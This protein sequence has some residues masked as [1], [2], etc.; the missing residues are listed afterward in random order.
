MIKTFGWS[1]YSPRINCLA[2]KYM[3]GKNLRHK[4]PA[5]FYE[6]NVISLYKIKN[7]L[8]LSVTCKNDLKYMFL[9]TKYILSQ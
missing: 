1:V 7:S 6:K 5:V 3:P 2:F 4:T 8:I 9:T